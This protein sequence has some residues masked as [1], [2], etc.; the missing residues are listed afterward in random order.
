MWSYPCNKPWKPMGLFDVENPTFSRQ[1]AHR[2]RRGCQPYAL[3]A[4]YPQDGSWYLFLLE[5]E[6]TPGPWWG[7]NEEISFFFISNL[8][9][10]S[11]FTFYKL[12]LWLLQCLDGESSSGESPVPQIRSI[13]QFILSSLFC[14][15][16][17]SV[18]RGEFSWASSVL[19]NLLHPWWGWKE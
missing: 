17:S 9:Q 2:L 10:Q 8:N 11:E 7:W 6:S 5:T 16:T 13:G 1:S 12:L 3:A 18:L 14:S 15:L 4:L 19:W